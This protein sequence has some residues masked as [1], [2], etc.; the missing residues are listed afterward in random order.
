MNF[1]TTTRPG[2]EQYLGGSRLE[3]L[4]ASG[5]LDDTE[6]EPFDRLAR[7]TRR[8]LGVET[9]LVS[10]VGSDR[11]VFKGQDGVRPDLAA[12]RGSPI[13]HSYCRFAVATG[14]PLVVDDA[15]ES[16]LLRDSPAIEERD[17]VAYAG[18]PLRLRGGEVAGT[19][20]V[21]EPYGREWTEDE[22]DMLTELAE[23][24]RAELDHRVRDLGAQQ[25]ETLALRL[26]DP[27]A[28]LGD[29][30]RATADLVETPE[31]LRLPRTADVARGR[32]RT[33]ETITGDLVRAA[34]IGQEERSSTPE[35][36]DLA[37][38]LRASV[39]LARSN[40]R[41]GDVVVEAP[42]HPVQVSWTRRELDR[43][44][45]LAVVTA[46]HHADPGSPVVASLS[47]ED[48]RAVLRVLC[49]GN[50]VS[51]TELLRVVTAFEPTAET[52]TDTGTGTDVVDVAVRSSGTRVR[53]SV[54][55]AVVTPGGT[56]IVARLPLCAAADDPADLQPAQLVRQRTSEE[57]S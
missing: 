28:R 57:G 36:V 42:S 32:Y 17:A 10:L 26:P 40:A 12:D 46:T 6:T 4:Y 9:A 5:L 49:P 1:D 34:T 39:A 50:A 33:V 23:L 45:A 22:I 24:A 7:L 16:V 15:R 56:S 48:G 44:L 43:A 41:P 29:A 11:Q 21:I 27:V 14:E 25:L 37:E 8:V 18:I 30:V 47:T 2:D 3:A 19:L 38:R 52:S 31:D 54:A 20:C 13:S 51:V 53:G 35:V 55:E